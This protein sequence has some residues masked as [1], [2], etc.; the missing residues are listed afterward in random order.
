MSRPPL[1]IDAHLEAIVEE[2]RRRGTLVLVAEPGAGKTTRVPCALERALPGEVWVLQPRRIAARLAA[3]RVAEERGERVGESVGYEVRFERALSKKTRIRF[4]TEALLMKKLAERPDLPGVSALVFDEFHERSV[5]SDLGLALARALRARR[6][7]LHL[8]V[9]SATLTAGPVAEYLDA[10]VV[11]VSGRTYPVEVEHDEKP[12]DRRLEVRVRAALAKAL[13]DPI[14]DVLVFLPGAAEIDRAMEEARVFEPRVE[15]AALHGEM[16]AEAQAKAIAPASKPKVIFATNVAETSLTIPSV[17]VVVDSGLARKARHSPWSGLPELVTARI[18]Q[19]SA[20]QRKGRAG[21]TAEGRCLRLYTKHDFASM[22]KHELPAIAREDLA[23]A[24]LS[25]LALGH[26]PR[27][28]P[29]FERPPEA[30]LAAAASLLERL[31]AHDDGVI[32][33]LGREMAR[34]PLHPR[35][36]RLARF[37]VDEGIGPRGALVAALLGE[38]EIRRSHL[39]A[40]DRAGRDVTPGPSD[41]LTRLELYEAAEAEGFDGSALRRYELDRTRVRAVERAAARIR[42]MLGVGDRPSASLDEEEERILRA[43]L[44]AFPD[45]VARRVEPETF[46]LSSGRA[47]LDPSCEVRDHELIVAIEARETPKGARI[48]VASRIEPE[49]LLEHFEDRLEDRVEIRFDESR[50]RLERVRELVFEGVVIER[51]ESSVTSDE[52]AAEGLAAYVLRRG[53]HA[54]FGADELERLFSRLE[55]A[56]AHGLSIEEDEATL[57]ERAL[58]AV[59]YGCRSIRDLK[60]RPLEQAILAELSPEARRR[61]EAIAP[62]YVSIPGRAKVRVDYPRG[63]EPFIESRMQDFFGALE[64]PKVAEGRV[65]LLLHLLAPNGRAVQ[66]TKELAG[67]WERHYPAIRKELMRRY[68]KHPFPEDP[69][70]AAPGRRPR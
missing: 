63:R 9:M 29:Y 10:E 13:A 44:V 6:P 48:T 20:E 49:W 54:Y 69:R 47:K 62:E 43:I 52:E 34:L 33:A 36:A 24:C 42:G 37:A 15:L 41:V 4:L 5:H 57:V 64:G 16:S 21:R 3:M 55:F 56:K 35:L 26:D 51:S 59:C 30:A 38:R 53:V 70:T 67:F 27:A 66:V 61:L 58:R 8:L 17:R 39:F 19:A 28:F 1:P 40:S 50:D 23:D 25:L 18:S 14:G 60:D 46:R 32:T 45:R 7:D 11:E 2:L 31:G 65:P 22:A 68:P 12:D